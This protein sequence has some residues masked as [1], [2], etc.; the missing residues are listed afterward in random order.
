MATGLDAAAKATEEQKRATLEAMARAGNQGVEAYKQAQVQ[1]QNFGL[2]AMD[3]AIGAA[4]GWTPPPAAAQAEVQRIVAQPGRLAQ[5]YIAGGQARLQGDLARQQVSNANY[6][7]QARAA[8]PAI[9]AD[10]DRQIGLMKARWEEQRRREEEKSAAAD[11]KAQKEQSKWQIEANAYGAAEQ[12]R[13]ADLGNQ[14]AL[15][16]SLLKER[17][18]LAQQETQ[19]NAAQ[20]KLMTGSM[21]GVR[22]DVAAQLGGGGVAQRGGTADPFGGGAKA[23]NDSGLNAQMA[24]IAERRRAIDAEVA[25]LTQSDLGNV[26]RKSGTYEDRFGRAAEGLRALPQ[27]QKLDPVMAEKYVDPMY[28]YQRRAAISA[29]IPETQARGMFQP[30]TP[31]EELAKLMATQQL[32]SF[33]E[34]GYK[35]PQ[36]AA[37]AARALDPSGAATAAKAGLNPETAAQIAVSPTYKEMEATAQTFVQGAQSVDDLKAT[38]NAQYPQNPDA[39]RLILARYGPLMVSAGYEPPTG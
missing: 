12:Q 24:Q 11:A 9:Q 27:D 39:V 14:T 33:N 18:A 1:T 6:F 4:V 36:E 34:T 17:D 8:V 25:R 29:G 20:S 38:L 15:R 5:D 16:D 30:P 2:Q 37:G 22:H 10:A 26:T 13:S 3:Q 35:S 31:S 19:L 7:D 32:G 28:Q 21:K 23:I